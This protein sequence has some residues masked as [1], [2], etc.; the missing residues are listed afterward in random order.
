MAGLDPPVE[1]GQNLDTPDLCA[2]LDRMKKL[3]ERLEDAQGNR[4][5]YRELVD[6]IQSEADALRNF[7]CR[8]D[9]K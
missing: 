1:N 3:C 4:A 7:V 2:R 6:Q 5:K 8:T 9:S